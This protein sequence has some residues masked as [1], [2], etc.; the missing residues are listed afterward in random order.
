VGTKLSRKALT[1]PNANSGNM[2][3]YAQ[4]LTI[5]LGE[6]ASSDDAAKVR[7]W[8]A[9]NPNEFWELGELAH[10]ASEKVVK[11]STSWVAQQESVKKRMKKLKDDLGYS[12]SNIV[13][14][15][16]ITQVVL[17]WARL[18]FLEASLSS[19]AKGQHSRDSAHY[20]DRRVTMAQGRYNQ[21]L[22][23]L[24]RIRKLKLPDITAI[25]A[26]VAY[27]NAG[28]DAPV[29]LQA[30]RLLPAEVGK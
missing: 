25:Q 17:N 19:A 6:D 18:Y 26:Q 8:M 24:A 30:M 7:A 10:H 14:Q 16:A 28:E 15:M 1:K 9:A 2:N 11:Y 21:A 3:D 5:G 27:V 20:W 13:E 23:T 4:M 12:S 22:V 29:E